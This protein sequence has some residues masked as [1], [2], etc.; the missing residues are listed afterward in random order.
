MALITKVI[1]A[2]HHGL[3]IDLRVRRDLRGRDS[4]VVGA[5]REIVEYAIDVCHCIL[6]VVEFEL[7]LSYQI[8][9]V[10]S[11]CTGLFHLNGGPN[12]G[13]RTPICSSSYG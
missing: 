7:S 13:I 12:G 4:L 5:T 11:Y 10:C 2:I 1:D 8:K 3:T 9:T 6:H